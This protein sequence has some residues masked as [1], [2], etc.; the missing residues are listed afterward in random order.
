M[1]VR[2]GWAA[3]PEG[4]SWWQLIGMAVLAGIGFTMSIFIT[5]LA[6]TDI[7]WQDISKLAILLAGIVSVLLGLLILQR[8][9]VSRKE[10]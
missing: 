5:L 2:L 9:S 10:D 8:A 7:E 3:L 4:V 1:V 6:F